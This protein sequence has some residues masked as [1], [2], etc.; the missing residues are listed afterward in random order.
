MYATQWRL[1]P[2]RFTKH[3]LAPILCRDLPDQDEK[4]FLIGRLMLE[5]SG[6]ES[7]FKVHHDLFHFRL[8]VGLSVEVIDNFLTLDGTG[9][10]GIFW[11]WRGRL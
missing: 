3:K 9:K 11:R 10:V 2:I 4:Q 1:H 8:L 6:F 5:R 7:V